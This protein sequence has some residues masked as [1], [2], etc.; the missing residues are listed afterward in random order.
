MRAGLYDENFY[1]AYYEDDDILWRLFLSGMQI[2]VLPHIM[3][4]HGLRRG[5]YLSG[6]TI[7]DSTGRFKREVQRSTNQHYLVIKWGSGMRY[8]YKGRIL[9]VVAKGLR[10]FFDYCGQLHPKDRLYED[11]FC[12]AYNESQSNLYD[13]KFHPFLRDC[14]VR[15][16]NLAAQCLLY[17]DD[18]RNHDMT[19]ISP[20]PP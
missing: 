18:F 14:L 10:S 9:E 4:A 19:S 13:W 3:V 8:G 16:G 11:L 15:E 12:T 6:T 1:P 7:E 5:I 2:V 20:S 17:L